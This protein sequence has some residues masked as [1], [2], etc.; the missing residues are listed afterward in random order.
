MFNDFF[1]QRGSYG[2]LVRSPAIG[3][4]A[5]S[6]DTVAGTDGEK[7][8]DFCGSASGSRHGFVLGMLVCFLVI[9]TI[10]LLA[11]IALVYA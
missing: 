1:W 7:V 2:G 11:Q 8:V 6:C 5:L 4:L 3:D 9:Q 10:L